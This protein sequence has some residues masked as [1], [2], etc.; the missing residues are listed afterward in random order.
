MPDGSIKYVH[1]VAH[2]MWGEFGQLEFVGAVKDITAARRVEEK[3]RKSEEEWRNV[4]ENNPTMYFMVDAAGTILAV[5]PFGAEQLGYQVDELTGRPMSCVFYEAD[6]EAT[7]SVIARC[8]EQPRQSISWEHRKVRKDGSVL[9]VRGTA[10]AVP[11]GADAILLV[12]GED[13]TERKHAEEKIREQEMELR[14]ILDAAPQH[15]A[16]LA[17]DGTRLYLNRVALEYHGLTLEQWQSADLPSRFHPDDWERGHRDVENALSTGSRLEFE[18]RVKRHD[19]KFCWFSFRFNPLR[20]EQGR[21]TRWAV[22]SIDIEDRKQATERL[23]REN[24]ALREEIDKASMFEEIVGALP[25]LRAVLSR[26]AKVSPT[27]STVLISG[28]TGQE[29][30]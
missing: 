10:R 11:R 13:I 24:I 3:I 14:Q 25:A 4:F 16:V 2:A 6:R 22:A 15:V 29:K 1:V 17:P 26:V 20:D 27:D 7:Q 28:E 12:A 8:F 19:G 9:W 5:N 21:I 23:R 30:S 18:A